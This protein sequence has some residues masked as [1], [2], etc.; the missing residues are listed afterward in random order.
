MALT[1]F[2]GTPGAR[3][4]QPSVCRLPSVCLSSVVYDV[5]AQRPES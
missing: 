5:V 2:N 1:D 3:H 4:E